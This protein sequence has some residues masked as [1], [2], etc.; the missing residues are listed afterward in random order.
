MKKPARNFLEMVPVRK[1]QE[2]TR[3][4]E[5][6]TLMIPKFKSPWMLKWFIPPRRCRH[7]RINL[8]EMGRRVW[9]LIDGTKNTGEICTL[10]E[11][12][13]PGTKEPLD[14][15]V[16]GFLRQLYKNRFIIFKQ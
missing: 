13:I 6:I 12:Q 15:R 5:R 14:I 11:K 1:V 7:F 2:F 10:L 3:E 4:G 16:T 9:D 8:D